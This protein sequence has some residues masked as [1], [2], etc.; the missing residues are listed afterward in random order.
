MLTLHKDFIECGGLCLGQATE[1]KFNEL[2]K[3]MSLLYGE[4][5]EKDK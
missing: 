5:S 3:S 1:I 4:K 2:I